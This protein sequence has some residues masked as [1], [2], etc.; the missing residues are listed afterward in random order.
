MQAVNNEKNIT[1]IEGK[2]RGPRSNPHLPRNR[3]VEAS[4]CPSPSIKKTRRNAIHLTL[5]ARAH[6]CEEARL[7]IDERHTLRHNFVFTTEPKVEP[8]VNFCERCWYCLLSYG[9]AATRL[10]KTR[11]PH[12]Y[13]VECDIRNKGGGGRGQSCSDMAADGKFLGGSAVTGQQ[14]VR[15]KYLQGPLIKTA[16]RSRRQPAYVPAQGTR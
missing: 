9:L 8:K 7:V 11:S 5:Q 6:L 15:D 16:Q 14:K 13:A 10:K 2:G 3:M 4:C 12:Q 1:R